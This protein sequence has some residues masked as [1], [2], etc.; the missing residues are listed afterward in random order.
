MRLS[1]S[2]R[3]RIKRK[4]KRKFK[5]ARGAKKSLKA[6]KQWQKAHPDFWGRKKEKIAPVKEK[7]LWEEIKE[8]LK[9]VW[10]FVL[11]IPLFFIFIWGKDENN[12]NNHPC[13]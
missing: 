1:H 4:R 6:F 5:R 7:N 13:L 10:L 8:L 12:H 3:H 9:K 11:S 2:E